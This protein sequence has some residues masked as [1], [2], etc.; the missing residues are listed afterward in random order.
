MSNKPSFSGILVLLSTS[1]HPNT[2]EMIMLLMVIRGYL[3]MNARHLPHS[4]PLLKHCLQSLCSI[5]TGDESPSQQG[6]LRLR[7]EKY[8]VQGHTDQQ[9]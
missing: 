6:K 5:C 9:Q 2:E 1:L 8:F 3:L 7:G 4:V